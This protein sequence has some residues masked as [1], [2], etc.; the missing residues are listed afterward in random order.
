MEYKQVLNDSL[1]IKNPYTK[2]LINEEY[3]DIHAKA[4]ECIRT[5]INTNTTNKFRGGLVKQKRDNTSMF[6]ILENEPTQI[7]YAKLLYTKLGQLLATLPSGSSIGVAY[8]NMKEINMSRDKEG[9]FTDY[10]QELSLI[11]I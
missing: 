6:V 9:T 5:F 2:K 1:A 8:G 4:N 7:R 3:I 10:F 11:H